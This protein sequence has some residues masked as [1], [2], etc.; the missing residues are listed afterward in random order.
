MSRLSYNLQQDYAYDT[1]L[2]DSR[3][4]LLCYDALRF[5]FGPE[6]PTN[7]IKLNVST[8]NPKKKG[9]KKIDITPHVYNGSTWVVSI[10]GQIETFDIMSRLRNDFR[11]L[12]PYAERANLW[13]KLEQKNH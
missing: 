13:V 6:I 5:I 1:L 12:F 2:R 10:G 11:A 8:K 4:C 7:N 9:W 3:G